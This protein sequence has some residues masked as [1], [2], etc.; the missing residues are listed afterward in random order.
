MTADPP[1]GG[2]EVRSGPDGSGPPRGWIALAVHRPVALLMIFAAV[3]VFGLISL[4]RLPVD[5]MPEVNRPTITVRTEYPGAAPEDVEERVSIRLEKALAVVKGLRRVTS[6]SR[7]ESSDV[8]LEFAWGADMRRA[9]QDVREKLDQA[10]LPDDAGSPNVLR[11]DPR[12]EP[13]LRIGLEGS[14]DLRTLRR[15]A[16]DEVERRLEGVGGIAAVRVRGGL[17]EEVSV[18][19]DEEKLR[20][21]GIT[22]ERIGQRLAEENL[23]RAAGRLYD[24]NTGYIVRTR[25]EFRTLEEI[26]EIPLRIDGA[27]V[28]RLSDVATIESG[29]REERVLTSIGGRPAV[30]IEILREGDAN[31]VD[32]ARRTRD[33]LFGTPE[34]QRRYQRWRAW[35][36]GGETGAAD[37]E[38]ANSVGTGP[39]AQTSGTP[40]PGRRGRDRIPTRPDFVAAWLPADVGLV[41]LGDQS[42][43]IEEAITDLERTAVLGGILAVLV[44]YLFLGRLSFTAVV[45]VSIPVS[46][47]A[48]FAPMYIGRISLNIM[49]LG[50]LALGV[51]ML[52]DSSIVVL[53]SI[54]RER[55]AG[56]VGADAAIVGGRRVAG[57]VFASTTTTVAVFLPIVFVEGIAGQFFRDQALTV[58]LSLLAS[59]VV[60][61]TLVPMLAGR[62]GGALDSG[63]SAVSAVEDR[64]QPWLRLQTARRLR[65][66]RRAVPG[67]ALRLLLGLVLLP[68]WLLSL[69][70]DLLR[71]V[72][73]GLVRGGLRL[74]VLGTGLLSRGLAVIG[75]PLVRLW[76]R[77]YQAVEARYVAGIRIA[78]GARSAVLLAVGAVVLLTGFLARDLGSELVPEV[79]RGEF[80]LVVRYPVGTPLETTGRYAR[81]VE[82][83]LVPLAGVRTVSTTVGRDPEETQET[84]DGEH[85]ARF[86]VQLEGESGGLTGEALEERT[87][88]DALARIGRIDD[89]EVEVRRPTLFSTQSPIEIELRG[90]DLAVLAELEIEVRALLRTIPELREVRSTV[91]AGSPE[92][93][94]FPDRDALARHGISSERIASVLRRKNLGEVVSRFRSVDR[95]IDMRL[96]VQEEDRGTIGDLLALEIEPRAGGT[97]IRLGDLLER[98]EP[99]E[100]PAQIRRIGRQRAVVISAEIAGVDLGRIAETIEDRLLREIDLP[101]DVAVEVVG[102]KKEM[103]SSLASLLSALA[104]AIF[105]VYVVMASQFESLLQPFVILFT[106]P[107]AAVGVVLALTLTGTALSVMVF[108]GMIVLA[109]IVVNNAIVLLDQVNQLRRRGTPL[110]E[111]LVEGG[112]RRLRPILMTT[113]TTVLAL[114]PVTGIF[115]RIPH[116]ALLDQ[117]LG[118]G[119]GAEI[120]A[121]LALTVIGGLLLS[122]LLTLFVVPVVYSLVDREGRAPEEAS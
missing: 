3:G 94:L 56:R 90:P 4:R 102:Q 2:E 119:Q 82:E 79:A 113:L 111:A 95:R 109:G 53:E 6:I 96:R 110:R 73:I 47:V 61:L 46:V 33:R 60:S 107:L 65:S 104:L 21:R 59:L 75:R 117:L 38:G 84:E 77:A 37:S 17:E 51:G 71:I 105:L 99:R 1:N 43:F 36:G 120:R 31:I 62:L 72:S 45:A 92:Y 70:L 13:V 58:V 116:P 41:L 28:L 35:S 12:L 14:R 85:T 44:L 52:V 10:F 5:L 15:L 55:E 74:G 9:V 25:N 121:P 101:P 50:G 40:T 67:V 23:D 57:A 106:I 97:G 69:V 93:H 18:L 11:Y 26:G 100:G 114:L 91:A 54:F 34:E 87:I 112:R 16:E 66:L 8:V 63:T 115:S 29:A 98:W 32:L 80:T 68:Y 89:H 39:E 78:L 64:V 86:A 108:I 27:S 76:S 30:Q 24:G 81:E 19:V 7:A 48:T 83:A 118:T 122:T 103:E 49:S 88:A 20:S 42:V 22:I